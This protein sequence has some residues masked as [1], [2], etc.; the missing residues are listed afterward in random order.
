MYQ[1]KSTFKSSIVIDEYQV[2]KKSPFV[3]KSTINQSEN[4]PKF[5]E[6]SSKQIK[7]LQFQTEASPLIRS[8]VV[9]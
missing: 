5:F 3:R 4:E 7:N 1:T 9:S 2:D 8:T 6:L